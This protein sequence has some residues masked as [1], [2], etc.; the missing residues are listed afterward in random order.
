MRGIIFEI[1]LPSN[2]ELGVINKKAIHKKLCT[3]IN[4]ES[5]ETTKIKN[6]IMKTRHVVH[7]YNS[8]TE[9]VTDG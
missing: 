7:A 6:V 9:E 3:T 5:K 4:E 8:R 1:M 2:K